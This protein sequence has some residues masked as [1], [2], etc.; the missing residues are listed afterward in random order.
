MGDYQQ[1]DVCKTSVFKA[2]R[3]LAEIPK[4]KESPLK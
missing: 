3:G 2:K 1:G 4:Q